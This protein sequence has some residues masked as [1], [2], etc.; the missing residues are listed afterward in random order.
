MKKQTSPNTLR[1]M[2]EIVRRD[3]DFWLRGAISELEA[4]GNPYY[5]WMAVKVC[6]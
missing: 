4:T 6:V 1:E 3:P 2:L 5:A